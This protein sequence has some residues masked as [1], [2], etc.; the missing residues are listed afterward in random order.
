MGSRNSPRSPDLS[1]GLALANPLSFLYQDAAEMQE[2]RGQPVAM[3]HNQGTTREI[4]ILIDQGN[5][6]VG[7]RNHSGTDRSRDIDAEMRPARLAVEDPLAAVHPAY[8]PRGGPH[9]P[10]GEIRPRRIQLPSLG[11]QLGFLP[12][13]L[14]VLGGRCDLLWRQAVDPL[15]LVFP[16]LDLDDLFPVLPIR[17]P[18]LELD[19]RP[20]VAVEPDQKQSVARN[21]DRGAV[22]L[23][24]RPRD[25]LALHQP[26]L[27]ESAFELKVVRAGGARQQGEEHDQRQR[28]SAPDDD[29]PLDALRILIRH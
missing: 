2:R 1:D 27:H 20:F 25:R 7:R 14:E 10:R 26:S 12:D 3:I 18:N 17:G 5:Y 13:T 24:S 8:P 21:P 28:T 19:L 29:M 11:H 22:Y 4:H 15:D 9:E 23:Y 6:T 16:G